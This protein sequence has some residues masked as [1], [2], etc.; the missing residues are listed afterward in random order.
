MFEVSVRLDNAL[1]GDVVEEAIEWVTIIEV[2]SSEGAVWVYSDAVFSCVISGSRR[3][4]DRG[5][6][7]WWVKLSTVGIFGCGKL[8]W[9]GGDVCGE[10]G[11]TEGLKQW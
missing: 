6:P 2:G 9:D 5:S 10:W 8:G 11:V 4:E 7:W 3:V 1:I